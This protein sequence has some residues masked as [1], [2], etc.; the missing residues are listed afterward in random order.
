MALDVCGV[1]ADTGRPRRSGA[2]PF[3]T[4]GGPVAVMGEPGASGVRSARL[5]EGRPA[6]GVQTEEAEAGCTGVAWLAM[7]PT[8]S[9]GVPWSGAEE[10]ELEDAVMGVEAIAG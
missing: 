1:L 5:V 7:R 8:P 6:A 9:H 10:W 4:G 2:A 3:T